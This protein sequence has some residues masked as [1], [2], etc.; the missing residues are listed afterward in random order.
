MQ[1]P[2]TLSTRDLTPI[3]HNRSQL[4]VEQLA[5]QAQ[6]LERQRLGV[7]AHE[8]QHRRG[9]ASAPVHE[10]IVLERI[11]EASDAEGCDRD[12]GV[13]HANGVQRR[14][15]WMHRF[16]VIGADLKEVAYANDAVRLGARHRVIEVGAPK[17]DGVQLERLP[18]CVDGVL[19]AVGGGGAPME[20][21]LRQDVAVCECAA[22]Q[23][24]SW[25]VPF[26]AENDCGDEAGGKLTKI[27]S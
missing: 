27:S 15:N 22:G 9:G 3:A 10:V 12:L 8:P 21:Q 4:I 1:Q 25:S 26:G 14:H 11:H 18:R 16:A 2:P 23:I 20:V 24:G 19:A 5:K 7:P 17:V 6:L 13:G